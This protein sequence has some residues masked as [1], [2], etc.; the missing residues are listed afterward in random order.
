MELRL[1]QK[2]IAAVEKVLNQGG[3]NEVVIKVENGRV[4]AFRQQKKRIEEE[5]RS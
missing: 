4:V 3:R 1:S 2:T 5:P